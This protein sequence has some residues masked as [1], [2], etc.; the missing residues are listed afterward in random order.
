MLRWGIFVFLVSLI[1]NTEITY[2]DIICILGLSWFAFLQSGLDP[3][4]ADKYPV[5][6]TIQ[7]FISINYK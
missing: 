4:N 7:L 5:L 1:L 3:V 2:N 6:Y